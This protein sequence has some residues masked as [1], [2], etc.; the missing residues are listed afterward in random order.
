MALE[1]YPILFK[2]LYKFVEMDIWVAIHQMCTI[3]KVKTVL[4]LFITKLFF[5]ATM[6]N[7]HF[8][9]QELP[10]VQQKSFQLQPLG[11][12]RIERVRHPL[13]VAPEVST[14]HNSGSPKIS[15]ARGESLAAAHSALLGLIRMPIFLLPHTFPG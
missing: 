5:K 9:V 3:T 8:G 13:G 11:L 12:I 7:E 10:F 14:E 15:A 6:T 4:G 2:G 1:L